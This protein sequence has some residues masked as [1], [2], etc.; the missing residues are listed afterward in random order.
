MGNT[1]FF[2]SGPGWD[3]L[4]KHEPGE[5]YVF[6]FSMLSN[7]PVPTQALS[8]AYQSLYLHLPIEK[9]VRI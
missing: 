9:K 6:H 5:T 8:S 2:V 4:E 7:H 3:I 1:W